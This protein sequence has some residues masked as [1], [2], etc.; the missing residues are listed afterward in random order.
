MLQEQ[1]KT[2]QTPSV[3]IF[4]PPP[5]IRNHRLRETIGAYN[6]GARIYAD[7]FNQIVGTRAQ[8]I[9]LAFD[10]SP[11]PHPRVLE[12]GCGN[13]RDAEEILKRTSR[14]TG[15]D[16]SEGMIALARQRM[17]RTEFV[18]G[19]IERMPLAGKFDIV[20]AF[21][22]LLHIPKNRLQ[23]V[24]RKIRNVLSTEG[25][26]H[27]SLK[28][29]DTYGEIMKRDKYGQRTFYLYSPE[30]ISTL[31]RRSGF[32]IL[33]NEEVKMGERMWMEILLRPST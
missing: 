19:D 23:L 4:P 31:A 1:E 26:F 15:V 9:A 17:P 8:D 22:S 18:L 28:H 20:F 5:W 24:L 16:A 25:A 27:I 32:A 10:A 12:I 11:A 3:T 7:K 21:A 6:A 29:A 13:G 30:D 2:S 14:Y 33:R